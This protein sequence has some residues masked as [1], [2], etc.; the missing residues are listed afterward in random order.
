MSRDHKL[1]IESTYDAGLCDRCPNIGL[2]LEQ[3]AQSSGRRNND[4]L[5][6]LHP[7][8]YLHALACSPGEEPHFK[9]LVVVRQPQ[10]L[11]GDLRRQLARRADDQRPD[12]PPRKPLPGLADIPSVIVAREVLLD[13]F[14]ACLDGRDE[15][16]EG[17]PRSRFRSD[18]QIAHIIRVFRAEWLCQ[19][20]EQG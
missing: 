4:I 12:S 17:L 5:A 19:C 6:A 11:V 13:A 1:V 10:R 18:K 14:D 7:V 20:G 8:P 2:R 16:R 15:E 9:V 3:I